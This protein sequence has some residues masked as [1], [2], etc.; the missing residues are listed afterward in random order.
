MRGPGE[1]AA[2]STP[3][4]RDRGRMRASETDRE[5]AAEVLKAAF[6]ERRLAKDEFD[7]RVGRALT[8]L[9]YADLDAL[10]TDLPAPGRQHPRPAAVKPRRRNPK[11]PARPEHRRARA[12]AQAVWARRQLVFLM[13][14]LL[15]M[16]TV[17]MLP[18]P[19]VLVV[20][21]LVVGVSA[22][23]AGP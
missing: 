15:V 8:A 7:L 10:T 11:P 19:V 3:G 18:S 2:E 23:Q 13:A 1:W 4:A 6:V 14:G 12:V 22:P 16:G 9:T 21:L 17:I 5:R 20:W